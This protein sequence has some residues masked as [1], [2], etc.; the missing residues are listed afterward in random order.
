MNR[1]M[2]L[3]LVS[4]TLVLS[5]GPACVDG[6]ALATTTHTSE[7]QPGTYLVANAFTGR[8]RFYIDVTVQTET[9]ASTTPLKCQLDM[10]AT[11]ASALCPNLASLP[12]QLVENDDEPMG[13]VIHVGYGPLQTALT[14]RGFDVL[15]LDAAGEPE[16]HPAEAEWTFG[17]WTCVATQA[18]QDYCNYTTCD[19]HGGGTVSVTEVGATNNPFLEPSC[20]LT[21][22]CLDGTTGITIDPPQVEP[23]RI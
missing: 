21:C 14:G 23:A 16:I 3:S 12:V 11:S 8:A 17:R 13:Q 4:F 2:S 5:A 1:T 7:I 6:P 20:E 10:G 15:G 18:D 9:G 22:E 19:G